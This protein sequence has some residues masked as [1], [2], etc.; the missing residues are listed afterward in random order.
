MKIGTKSILYGAHQ[1]LLHPVFV[2]WAW[3]KLY[4]FPWDPRIWIAFF[5]HDLGYWGKPN[6]DGVEGET[7]VELG[8]RI[9]H[10][11]FDR[12][13]RVE[14]TEMYP[15]LQRLAELTD[16]G[17]EVFDYNGNGVT[18][19][20]MEQSTKWRDFTMYHSSYYAKKNG[21][22]PS[23]LCFADKLAFC[24]TPKWMYII[25]TSWTG[26]ILEYMKQNQI[27]KSKSG[28]W[29]PTLIDKLFWYESVD[30][31]CDNWVAEHKD[32]KVDTWTN[33]NRNTTGPLHVLREDTYS[34]E[35]INE[36]VG[37][38]VRK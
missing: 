24:V 16:D 8:A 32:G 35:E 30:M 38:M 9:M 37:R 23:K 33:A 7:H 20:R 26:E 12:M 22:T 28:N 21:A 6:M 29:E 17:W 1:F 2:A 3:I 11:L 27:F 19:E 34:N 18:Y 13:E 14:M 5:V 25:M 31:Y 4:G 36:M 15:S 10:F